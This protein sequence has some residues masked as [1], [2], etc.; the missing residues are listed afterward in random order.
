MKKITHKTAKASHYDN[1]AKHYDTFNEKNSEVMNKNIER[2]LKKYKVK[3]VL[4]MTCG[5]GSQVFWLTKR[6]FNVVGTD[7]NAN[8]LKVAKSKA[9]KENKKLTFL[10]GDM[11][12][13][14]VGQFDAVISIFNAVGHL[15]KRD[16]EKAMHNVARNLKKGGYYIF[17]IN[18]L[19]YL[20]KDNNITSLTI[21][22]QK[23]MGDLKLREI[24]YSTIDHHGTLASFTTSSSQKGTQKP[25]ISSSAQTLQVYSAKQLKDMLLRCGFKVIGHCAIDGSRFIEN[26]SQNIITIAKKL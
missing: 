12:T 16:F 6:G 20:Q 22:W 18:N 14:Q 5:T 23:R 9:L 15:T 21:D 13:I 7:I 2:I 4:D 24:Q 8:M 25:K 1:D 3:S 11:R 26:I 10:K 19:S 17:D